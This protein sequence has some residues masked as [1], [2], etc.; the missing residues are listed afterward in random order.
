MTV[1]KSMTLLVG[2]NPFHG[3]SHLSQER[4]RARGAE[5]GS[6]EYLAGLVETSLDNC[7]DGFMFSVSDVTLSILKELRM[8]R[9]DLGFEAYAIVPYAYEYVRASTH[10]GG[11]LGLGKKV[12]KDIIF[13]GN[14]KAAAFGVKGIVFT[15]VAALLK[16]YVLYEVSRIKSSASNNVRINSILLHEIVTEMA[17]ALDMDWLVR[18]YIDFMRKLKMSPGFETRNFPYLVKKFKEWNIGFKGL[19]I[20]TPF[21]KVGFQMNPSKEECEK[22]LKDVEGANVIGMSMLAAGYLKPLEAIDYLKSLRNLNGAVIGVSK[23]HHARE[24]FRIFRERLC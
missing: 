16:T 11:F 6:I 3:I 8:K 17:L 14:V 5:M 15:D 2:D 7:A 9:S 20:A 13:S 24:T 22:A 12:A 19:T 23:E 4:S 10:A 1:N 18:A 21:N